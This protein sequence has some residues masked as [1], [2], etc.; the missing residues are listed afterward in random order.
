MWIC[1]QKTMNHHHQLITYAYQQDTELGWSLNRSTRGR[2]FGVETLVWN[3]N[4]ILQIELWEHDN[5]IIWIGSQ[6]KFF[7]VK[8]PVV[9]WNRKASRTELKIDMWLPNSLP[10]PWKSTPAD[11]PTIYEMNLSTTQIYWTRITL[12]RAST[13]VVQTWFKRDALF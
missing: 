13:V 6:K 3:W 11:P 4:F 1:G 7:F 12:N 8:S 10:Q 5:D 2:K 9:I